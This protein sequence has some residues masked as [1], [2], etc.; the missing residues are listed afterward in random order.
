MNNV[1]FTWAS[2]TEFC[3]SEGF[4]VFVKSLDRALYESYDSNVVFFTHDMPKDVEETLVGTYDYIVNKVDPHEATY[5]IGDRHLHYWKWLVDFED[6]YDYVFHTDCKDVVFQSN[7]FDWI[8]KNNMPLTNFKI[9]QRVILVDE[10][11]P[12]SAN[13]FHLIEQFEF[14]KDMPKKDP[15]IHPILNGGTILGTESEMKNLFFAVWNAHIRI[16]PKVTDQAA[17]NYLYHFLKEDQTFRVSNPKEEDFCLT[18]EGL[19][20]GHVQADFRDGLFYH[21]A[22]GEPYAIVHQWDRS[23]HAKE[24]LA[25]YL[26]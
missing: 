4:Q 2:G 12:P 26:E 18:G 19:K 8:R 9:P 22:I 24:V 16:S 14:Q 10:G 17:L 25:H 3:R 11:M 15:R 1:V 21:K 5:P 13:G 7:P 20:N 6:N 23:C